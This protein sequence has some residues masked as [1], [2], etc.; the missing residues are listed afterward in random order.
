MIPELAQTPNTHVN[1]CFLAQTFFH[2]EVELDNLRWTLEVQVKFIYPFV[3]GNLLFLASLAG[4]V[5]WHHKGKPWECLEWFCKEITHTACRHDLP[6]PVNEQA[7]IK[8]SELSISGYTPKNNKH[9]HCKNAFQK[10]TCFHS[11]FFRGYNGLYQFREA[12]S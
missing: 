2:V 12:Y 11:Q 1:Q 5:P 10:E 3:W 6:L 8:R 4:F 9:G 7:K